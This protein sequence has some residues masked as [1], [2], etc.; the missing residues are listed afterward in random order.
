M[1]FES[2]QLDIMN[3]IQSTQGFKPGEL[4]MIASGRQMGK[5]ILSGQALQRLMDDLNGN[6]VTDLKFSEGTV[7]G[8]SY[9]CVEPV[10]GNWLEMEAWCIQTCGES[11][12][13][14]WAEEKYK[15]AANAGE[16]WYGNNRKFWFREEQDR[17]MFVLRWS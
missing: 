10:G 7:Y 3:K 13:S 6:P 1:K 4:H 11:T 17:T 12:Y 9:Y 2:W 5:S 16:R 8:S 15:H 14:I